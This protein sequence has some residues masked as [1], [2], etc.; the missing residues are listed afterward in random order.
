[1]AVEAKKMSQI[2][3]TS[4]LFKMPKIGIN[5]LILKRYQTHPV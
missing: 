4:A 1:M 5:P 2:L 3:K